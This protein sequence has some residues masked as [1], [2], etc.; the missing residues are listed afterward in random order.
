MVSMQQLEL[1]FKIALEE[2]ADVPEQADVL[3]LWTEF[4][5]DLSRD[6]RREQLRVAGSVLSELADLCEA[7]SEVLG[8]DW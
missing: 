2:V 8:E 4:E 6:C 1:N 5:Q 3:A 7:K